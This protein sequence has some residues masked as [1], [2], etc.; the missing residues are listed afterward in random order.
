MLR[1]AFPA[2]VPKANTNGPINWLGPGAIAFVDNLVRAQPDA[3]THA[4]CQSRMLRWPSVTHVSLPR[5]PASAPIMHNPDTA[6]VGCAGPSQA[7]PTL[8]F[9]LC[10]CRAGRRRA[11]RPAACGAALQVAWVLRGN[12]TIPNGSDRDAQDAYE[13]GY[14][15]A[16]K[17]A[18]GLYDAHEDTGSIKWPANI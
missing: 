12:P 11:D 7:A 10:W 9:C 18:Q 16:L 3:L 6:R 13:T 15:E 8:T 14:G 2:R 17:L 1:A 4:P 5:T